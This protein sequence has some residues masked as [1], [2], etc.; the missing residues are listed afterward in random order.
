M[1]NDGR[2]EG[3]SLELKKVLRY[4]NKTVE[5]LRTIWD[6]KCKRCNEIKP[7]R[8]HHCAVCDTCVFQMDHHCPWVNNC[9]G[10]DNMRFFLLFIFY[11]FI[12][13]VYSALTI[14]TIWNNSIYKE[15]H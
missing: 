1:E 4:R 8:A 9:L 13:A 3:V 7:A 11:L 15:N 6:K 14:F 2:F 10:A 5:Q 12:G